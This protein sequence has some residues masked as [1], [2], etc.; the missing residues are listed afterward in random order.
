MQSKQRR[1]Y[2]ASSADGR[3]CGAAGDVAFTSLPVWTCGLKPDDA[4]G[5]IAAVELA[6]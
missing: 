3:A 2:P 6:S 4:F 1:D 5:S